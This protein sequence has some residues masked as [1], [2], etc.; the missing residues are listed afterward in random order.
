MPEGSQPPVQNTEQ[1]GRR[2]STDSL[3]RAHT[4]NREHVG[5][6]LFIFSNHLPFSL[7]FFHHPLIS[8]FIL[9]QFP[10]VATAD[11]AAPVPTKFGMCL[12]FY[13]VEKKSFA[14]ASG[15]LVGVSNKGGVASPLRAALAVAAAAE[16]VCEGRLTGTRSGS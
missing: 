5:V 14:P 16:P 1:R 11:A 10:F 6:V 12:L 13:G 4:Q 15:W 2:W 8:V 7:Y 9:V 3:S